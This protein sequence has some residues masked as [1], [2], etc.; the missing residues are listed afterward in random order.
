MLSILFG[1]SLPFRSK[2]IVPPAIGLV[3]PLKAR[4]HRR[5]MATP[6]R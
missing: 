3:G 5:L 2:S 6:V 1:P 4:R